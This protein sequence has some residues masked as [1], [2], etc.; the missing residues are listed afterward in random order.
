MNFGTT[1]KICHPRIW[2]L[3]Q[4]HVPG[5]EGTQIYLK[6]M[7]FH[8]QIFLSTTLSPLH[9]LHCMFYCIYFLRMW[10]EWLKSSKDFSEVKNFITVNLYT[11]LELNA[12]ALLNL[13]LKCIKEKDF[14]NFYP[15]I[16]SSQACEGFFRMLRSVA[17]T[18]SMMVNCSI[19][20][21]S[22]K[23]KQIEMLATAASY[24]FLDFP[25]EFPKPRFLNGSFEKQTDT[26]D[27]IKQ[28]QENNSEITVESI[29]KVLEDAKQ[30]AIDDCKKLGMS[31]KIAAASEI[32]LKFKDSVV[33]NQSFRDVEDDEDD[34]DHNEEDEEDHNEE[35][36]DNNEDPMLDEA[37][38]LAAINRDQAMDPDA[39][40]F[41]VENEVANDVTLDNSS[42]PSKEDLEFFSAFDEE[43]DLPECLPDVP[44]LSSTG[45]FVAI[46]TTKDKL[47][48]QKHVRKSSLC[49]FFNN[50][51]KLSSDRLRRVQQSDIS[52]KSIHSDVPSRVTM[53][54]KEST[55]RISGYCVFEIPDKEINLIGIIKGFAN[56]KEKTAKKRMYYKQDVDV[57]DENKENIGV[58]ATWFGVNL[59]DKT[60]KIFP[61]EHNYILLKHYQLTIPPP[62]LVNGKRNVL[63]ESTVSEICR[64]DSIVRVK[65]M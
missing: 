4:K 6:I 62:V 34:E 52:Q 56:V 53:P 9:C 42:V 11:C 3:L 39:I 2:K 7:F 22:H 40:N 32:Q 45:P 44:T 61:M 30:M 28:F 13:I 43:L 12:H 50:H 27:V 59:T 41:L 1:M 37:L 55:V 23:I 54:N 20:G 17:S 31:I 15:W 8:T 49:W 16:Y 48:K 57:N 19:L 65:P 36:D 38:G 60:L 24:K 26:F 64:M 5:C 51:H 18:F 58:S 10:R 35:D 46:K 21:F 29:I 25:L 63:E 47:K 14:K 33:E